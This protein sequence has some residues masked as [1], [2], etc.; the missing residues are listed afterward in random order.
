M[1]ESQYFNYISIITEIAI[2]IKE[3]PKLSG[4]TAVFL[5]PF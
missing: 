2:M 3:K 1:N 5:M 4:N